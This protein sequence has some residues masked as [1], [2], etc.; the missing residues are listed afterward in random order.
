MTRSR[1]EVIGA[2][3]TQGE[4]APRIHLVATAMGARRICAL[5]AD[6]EVAA[7]QLLAGAAEQGPVVPLDVTLRRLLPELQHLVTQQTGYFD[8]VPDPA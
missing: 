3:D 2:P 4:L 5:A 1:S 8:R 7:Q 6:L